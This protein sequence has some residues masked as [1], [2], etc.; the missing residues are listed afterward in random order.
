MNSQ[1]VLVVAMA[2][3]PASLAA[4]FASEPLRGVELAPGAPD[5]LVTAFAEAGINT[6]VVPFRRQGDLEAA[7]FQA[8]LARWGRLA[9]RHKVRCLP[10]IRLFGP[11]DYTG[12][13]RGYRRALDAIAG[14]RPCVCP[15]DAAYWAEVVVPRVRR[16]A[17]LAR[18]H[19]LAGALFELQAT[20]AGHE[21]NAVFCYCT[22]CWQQFV[23]ARCE[24]DPALL[25]LS[26]TARI[27]AV[28]T[29]GGGTYFVFLASVVEGEMRRAVRAA[30]KAFPGV[31]LGVYNYWHAWLHHGVVRAMAEGGRPPA[32]L[33]E[34]ERTSF[35]GLGG[36]ARR[37]WTSAGLAL[38]PVACLPLD[39]YL[40]RDVQNQVAALERDQEGFLLTATDSLWRQAP[41]RFRIHPSHGSAG[42]FAHA[43]RSG[44]AGR[45]A[46]GAVLFNAHHPL[47]FVP[48]IAPYLKGRRLEQWL[49]QPRRLDA[50]RDTFAPLD[51]KV[52]VCE[53]P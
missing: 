43:I 36:L 45:D 34:I 49:P 32:V 20:L 22:H 50:F 17:E 13:R 19:G 11:P 40:P 2:I 37:Q 25:K 48:R 4:A 5:S 1:S 51:G 3:V 28:P 16:M 29:A 7:A 38:Q 10:V 14:A 53:L 35:G 6:V 23:K 31:E 9:A 30:R 12:C 15:T 18:D 44:L 47:Q 33:G 46:G 42:A 8:A 26:R 39:Y 27:A 41:D 52:Y 24:G 21:Y